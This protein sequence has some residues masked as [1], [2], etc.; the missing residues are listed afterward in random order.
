MLTTILCLLVGAIVGFF[1]AALCCA[2]AKADL[3][4][5]NQKLRRI[6]KR[7]LFYQN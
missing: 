1:A 7:N 4:A 2:A 6:I 3:I 5:E